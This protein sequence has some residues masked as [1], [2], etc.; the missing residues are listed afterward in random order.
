MK[1]KKLP[2]AKIL[3]AIGLLFMSATL[4]IQHYVSLPDT[5][6]GALMGFSIG[7]MIVAL[8]KKK[9]RPTG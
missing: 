9:V 4:I 2:P 1:N 6:L 8:V 5:W 3:I 7:I